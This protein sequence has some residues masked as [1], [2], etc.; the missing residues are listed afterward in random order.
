MPH[1]SESFRRGTLKIFLGY[2]AG[3]GKTYQMLDE[4]HKLK[5]EGVDVVLG[6]FEPHGRQDT[7][8]KAEGL[9]VVPRRKVE[10]RGAVFGETDVEA[11]LR[12]RPRVCVIDEFAHTNV[13]GSQRAKR[14][15]DVQV[16][17]EAGINVLTTLNVQHLESL[18]DQVWQF[19]GIRVRETIPDWV[20]KQ[21]DE[22]V[23]VDLPPQALLNRLMRG[24]VY[25]PEKARQA[26]ENFFKESTL[27][28]LRE[29]AIRQTAHEV[30]VRQSVQDE[31]ET[32]RLP[33]GDLDSLSSP[34]AR[35]SDRILIL[36]TEDPSSAA[37]IRRGRRVADYLKAECF[38]VCVLGDGSLRQ[39]PVGQREAVEK[40]MTFA[41]NLH[42]EARLLQGEDVAR[43][44]VD[45]AR[46]HKVT[47][48]FLARPQQKE[49]PMVFGRGLVERVVRLAHDIQ[50]TIVAERR[51]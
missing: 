26:M 9:E 38:A 28:A 40:H 33:G 21:A 8:T 39:I 12:R 23:M 44:L 24:V 1:M 3:V 20:V 11:I 48:I 4:A 25:A 51:R 13:P 43:T 27:V 17:L 29:L 37:L 22:V 42:I 50:V 34:R 2:A 14:W 30:D 49:W 36:V 32:A 47:Q 35:A 19:T 46:L 31:A 5:N 45:F 10:Y 16:L 18:N 7:I 6:Y 15:E 41:R